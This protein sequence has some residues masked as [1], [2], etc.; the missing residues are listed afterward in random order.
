M[1]MQ[2]GKEPR[3]SEDITLC[4][5]LEEKIITTFGKSS[6]YKNFS[7]LF[8]CI[9]CG[10]LRELTLDNY[11][12]VLSSIGDKKY[13]YAHIKGIIK[14]IRHVVKYL[15]LKRG[16]VALMHCLF[17]LTKKLDRLYFFMMKSYGKILK[18]SS[19]PIYK[20]YSI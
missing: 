3:L 17:I 18:K 9:I 15:G 11:K 16:L 5:L 4:K 14:N 6:L 8:Y 1:M 10:Q 7:L 19:S 12:K 20:K 13:F 2:I